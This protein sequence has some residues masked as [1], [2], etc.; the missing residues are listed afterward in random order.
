VV[1]NQP[2]AP[3]WLAKSQEQSAHGNEGWNT[4]RPATVDKPAQ[5]RAF[6]ERNSNHLWQEFKKSFELER[7]GWWVG[8]RS[9]LGRKPCQGQQIGGNV[10]SKQHNSTLE[11]SKYQAICKH[12]YSNGTSWQQQQERTAGNSNTSIKQ[13]GDLLVQEV[14][15]RVGGK[16]QDRLGVL[17]KNGNNKMTSGNLHPRTTKGASDRKI[18]QVITLSKTVKKVSSTM[19]VKCNQRWGQRS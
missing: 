10:Q 5:I 6:N 16:I 2:P 9:L 3:A 18:E 12:H 11:T 13:R 15:T 8:Q 7:H 19:I 1:Q 4:G 17:R 14:L